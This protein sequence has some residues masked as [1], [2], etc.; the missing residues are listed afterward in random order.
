MAIEDA[1]EGMV[2]GTDFWC[3]LFKLVF[4]P[5][6]G[7]QNDLEPAKSTGLN[8]FKF[9]RQLPR[10]PDELCSRTNKHCLHSGVQVHLTHSDRTLLDY[11][12]GLLGNSCSAFSSTSIISTLQTWHTLSFGEPFGRISS[13]LSYFR[14]HM[15][16]FIR[17]QMSSSTCTKPNLFPIADE[18]S[19][20]CCSTILYTLLYL[21]LR[22]ALGVAI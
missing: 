22:V 2:L 20:L 19:R 11:G 9:P 1:S 8:P 7:A 6:V 3:A 15:F 16:G 13:N 4:F 17:V 21:Y 12:Y 10:V 5:E 18:I 14:R